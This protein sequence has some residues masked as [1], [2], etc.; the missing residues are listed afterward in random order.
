MS[1]AIPIG[2][3]RELFWDEH[4]INTG[5]TNAELRLHEPLIKEVVLDHNEPWEG[6]GCTYHVI[7]KDEYVYRMYYI[8][9]SMGWEKQGLGENRTDSNPVSVCYAESLD[10]KHWIKPPLIL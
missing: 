8:A 5:L 10:G 3:R 9:C 2:N 1:N 4:L 6:D 7:L